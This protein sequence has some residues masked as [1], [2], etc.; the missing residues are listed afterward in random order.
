MPRWKN[1]ELQRRMLMPKNKTYVF[2]EDP[3][4]GWL[5]V[6]LK[7]LQTLG[8]I[9]K[10]SPYSYMKGK[11]AYLEEDR[12]LSIFIQA[13]GVGIRE[14]PFKRSY[15]KHTSIRSYHGYD[16]AEVKKILGVEKI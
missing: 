3:G 9:E 5:A 4:H 7:E 6:K 12:D 15:R 1:K 16:K 11:T 10:I 8:I 13:K 14:L 2:H